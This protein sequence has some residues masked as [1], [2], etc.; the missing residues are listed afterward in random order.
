[1]LTVLGFRYRSIWL[2]Y[3]LSFSGI[4]DGSSPSPHNGVTK[5]DEWSRN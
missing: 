2:Y 3:Y 1:M 4:D 5:D